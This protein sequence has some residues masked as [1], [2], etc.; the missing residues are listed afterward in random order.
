MK[1]YHADELLLFLPGLFSHG[2][3]TILPYKPALRTE[4]LIAYQAE[5]GLIH[6]EYH[7]CIYL[8]MLI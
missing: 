6:S 1:S 4:P 5:Q 7:N 2:D 3:L 8:N